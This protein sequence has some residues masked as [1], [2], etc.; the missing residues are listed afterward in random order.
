MRSA[1]R[2]T[3]PS[4]ST[5]APISIARPTTSPSTISA[6]GRAS[7]PMPSPTRTWRGCPR[8]GP[9]RRSRST[10]AKAWTG[11]ERPSRSCRS[12]P[13]RSSCSGASRTF[14]T[15][16]S[17]IVSP[18]PK[19]RSRNISPARCITSCGASGPRAVAGI[20]GSPLLDWPGCTSYSRKPP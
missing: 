16:R 8:T 6:G 10:P 12:G 2:A 14:P 9:P 20:S 19:A 5:T 17:P 3:A 15:G 1:G 13:G 18:Y 7:G 4:S 11:C